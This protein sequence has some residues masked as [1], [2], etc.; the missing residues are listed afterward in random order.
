MCFQLYHR[1]PLNYK[2]KIIF[3][4]TFTTAMEKQDHK[5]ELPTT[6]HPTLSIYLSGNFNDQTVNT[7]NTNVSFNRG[8][9]P[10]ETNRCVDLQKFNKNKLQISSVIGG[11]AS[12]RYIYDEKNSVPSIV[13]D[14][15]KGYLQ[16]LVSGL[17]IAW[18]IWRLDFNEP[19]FR[20][21]NGTFIFII[22]S[23]YVGAL[24]GGIMAG[25][26]VKIWRKQAIYVNS[27]CERVK[28]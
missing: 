10:S 16:L 9:S 8:V 3:A 28:L 11:K 7:A 19:W 15:F 18:G 26:I 21:A 13:S 1:I 6:I 2:K 5:K 22:L 23:F 24:I 12:K 27:N 4:I 14:I 17:H 20:R 25:C